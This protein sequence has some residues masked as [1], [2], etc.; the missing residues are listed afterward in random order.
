MK[1]EEKK[2]DEM[3]AAFLEATTGLE[4]MQKHFRFDDENFEF[5]ENWNFENFDN[6]VEKDEG[7]KTIY[8]VMDRINNNYLLGDQ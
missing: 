5:F 3:N 4:R 2:M 6:A 1:K 8:K 7:F